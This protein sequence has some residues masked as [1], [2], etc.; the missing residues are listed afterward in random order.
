VKRNINRRTLDEQELIEKRKD[1]NSKLSHILYQL[2]RLAELRVQ[3]RAFH[4]NGDQQVM[5]LSKEI[6]TVLRSSPGDEEHILCLTNVA[7]KV[8]QVQVTLSELGI[9]EAQWYDLY[10]KRGWMA[11]DKKLELTLQ[12]YDVVWLIPFVELERSIES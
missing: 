9:D 4:P 11:K 1:P 7:N 8:S 3:H 12:P 10:G 2:G 5:M 6:F